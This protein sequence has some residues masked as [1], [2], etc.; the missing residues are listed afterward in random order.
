[1]DARA[2]CA[3][4]SILEQNMED[5]TSNSNIEWKKNKG[6]GSTEKL[7]RRIDKE[8]ALKEEA[9]SKKPISNTQH[10]LP[11]QLPQGLKKLRK[12]I[13][14]VYDEDE[15]EEDYYTFLPNEPMSS[16]MNALYDDERKQLSIRENTFNNQKLQQD[17]GRIEAVRMANQLSKEF[18]FGKI[19][20]SIINENMQNATLNTRDFEKILKDDVMKKAKISTKQL[21][22]AETVNLLR[23]IKRIKKIAMQGKEAELKAIE[24]LKIEDIISAGERNAD[25]NKVAE[26]IL[27]KSGRKN[28]KETAKVI[29]DKNPNLSKKNRETIKKIEKT[30][31]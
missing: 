3:D 2:T 7:S 24:G 27:Q 11:S 26:I 22:K 10:P 4:R 14:E 12:K 31:N 19:D 9:K 15:E 20:K 8:K 18:G 28:K 30:R 17:A 29:K 23:G 13:K 1:M 16:L 21:S 5:D 25:D 6:F